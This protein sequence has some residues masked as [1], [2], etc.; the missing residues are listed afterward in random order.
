MIHV[1][2]AGARLCAS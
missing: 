1:Y 2:I